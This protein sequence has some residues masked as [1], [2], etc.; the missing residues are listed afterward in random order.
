[1]SSVW[2]KNL[3][4][5]VFGES[6]GKGIG[7]VVDGL[8]AGIELDIPLIQHELS[9]R[10]PGT[11]DIASTRKEADEF[12]ILSGYFNN[13]TTGAPLCA[14]IYNTDIRSG[15]YEAIKSLMRPGHA[16]YTGYIKYIGANDYRGGGHFSGRLTAPMV[17]AGAIAKQM[18][19]KHQVK[20]GSHIA[21]IG[22]H[23]DVSFDPVGVT[24]DLLEKL[25][26]LDFPTLDEAAG[27]TMR[28]L[29][30]EVKSCGDS[31]G[32][33][34]ECAIVNL[35]AGVGSP[36]FDSIEGVLSHML[37]SIPGV[38]G[39]EFGTG[40]RL[41]EMKG[42]EAND[43]FYINNNSIH[44]YTNHSG[45]ILGGI[46]NGM[47]VVFRVVLKPT[48]SISIQQSTVDIEKMQAATISVNG[49]HDPCIVP[50][51]VPVIE[52]ATAFAMLDMYMEGGFKKL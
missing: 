26:M 45:G 21:Q 11:G 47:P 52:A 32:G 18:L 8:P 13:K 17:F 20:V 33:I 42:S 49:R 31:I 6:H 4:L 44:T 48:P 50:R 23:S 37:F 12:E 19:S 9:R 22:H 15:D 35:P 38:K 29:I 25:H 2:G 36:I 1:M 24:P 40:F 16:D 51:A 10:M 14:V 30:S 28:T 39:I 43:Q 34:I 3:K 46:S 5:S 41:A 27:S 7:V